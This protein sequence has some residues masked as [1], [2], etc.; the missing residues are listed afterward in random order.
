MKSKKLAT[1]LLTLV[2]ALGL[3]P[4]SV[5]VAQRTVTASSTASITINS[6]VKNDVLAAYKVVD[7]TYDDATNTW[8]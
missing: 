4:M 3:I 5:F 1:L 2:F 8:N 7:L 6:A